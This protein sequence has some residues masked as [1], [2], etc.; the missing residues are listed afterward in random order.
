M[1]RGE[2]RKGRGRWGRE[3]GGGRVRE[4]EGGVGFGLPAGSGCLTSVQTPEASVT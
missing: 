4:G 2:G 3:G 1:G